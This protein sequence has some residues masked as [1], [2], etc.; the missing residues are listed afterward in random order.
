V[1]TVCTITTYSHIA[2]TLALKD[3]ALSWCPDLIFNVLI[4]DKDDVSHLKQECTNFFTIKDIENTYLASSL[5]KKY[6]K[7][8]DKLRW[9]L[10]P[11]FLYFLLFDR[12]YSKAIYADNDI[13]FFN[14]FSFLFDNLD[15]NDVLLCPHWRC[16][17]PSVN[18]EWFLV[19][20]TDG[21]YNAGF[22]AASNKASE[23][24][25]WWAEACLFK[26]AKIYRKG[27][28]DDQKYLDFIPVIFENVEIIKHR[29]C[30][31]AYW[32]QIENKRTKVKDIVLINSKWK[33]I[34][35][36][37]TKELV[38]AIKNKKDSELIE[39]LGIYKITLEKYSKEV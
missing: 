38:K 7:E 27:L 12:G 25:K 1:K 8:K 29:G 31:V 21:F 35:I 37:F 15:K 22:L 9:C 16:A 20:F 26:C 3:S 32:N 19:N 5:I 13:F 14:N 6:S 36:H 23:P 18:K 34:F 24:L 11:V 17:K 2:N 10:K 33:I 39:Y 30:N 28:F 4:T